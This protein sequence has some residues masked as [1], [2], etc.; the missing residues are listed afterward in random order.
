LSLDGPFRVGGPIE[1]IRL[2]GTRPCDSMSN[3]LSINVMRLFAFLFDASDPMI[4]TSVWM[5]IMI[6]LMFRGLSVLII[7]RC[8]LLTGSAL[9]VIHLSRIFG[10]SPADQPA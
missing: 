2:F 9:R 7:T 3:R 6:C 10:S 5:I 8:N 1:A 4:R